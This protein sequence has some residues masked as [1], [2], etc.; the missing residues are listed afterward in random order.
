[1]MPASPSPRTAQQGFT[2]LELLVA[3]TVF[4]VLTVL[5]IPQFAVW[6]QSVKLRS[7]SEALQ[8]DLRMA[9]GEAI[10]Q[11]RQVTFSLIS[12]PG[13]SSP[14][15][16]K[17]SSAG[18]TTAPT[19]TFTALNTGTNWMAY[20]VPVL[21]GEVYR[22]VAGGDNG[23]LEAPVQIAGFSTVGTIGTTN[24]G[25]TANG[26]ITFSSLGRIAAD[27]HF[28]ITNA[29]GRTLWVQVNTGGSIRLCDPNRS[30]T[31]LPDGC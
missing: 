11:N 21:N 13:A 5:A 7:V 1:M 17:S 16:F 10:R 20:T 25:G 19:S 4:S 22:Y 18:T 24:G 23:N 12:A 31:T 27:Q 15:I 9:Q 14:V 2:L 3:I 6:T 29:P 28:A 8:N 30:I 26:T